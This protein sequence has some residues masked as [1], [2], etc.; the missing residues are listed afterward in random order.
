MCLMP[1][2]TSKN[3]GLV[4]KLL[5]L[6]N[7]QGR[8]AVWLQFRIGETIRQQIRNERKRKKVFFV[9]SPSDESAVGLLYILLVKHVV[10]K[11]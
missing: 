8:P 9:R 10:V 7:S 3:S 6:H 4:S 1:E 11:R 2:H 5:N